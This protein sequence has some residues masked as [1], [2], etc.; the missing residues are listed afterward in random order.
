[1]DLT[2]A[3]FDVGVVVTDLERSLRFYEGALGLEVEREI[4][5]PHVGRMAMLRVGEGQLKLVERTSGVSESAIP[6]GV[7]AAVA[8][9][10]YCTFSVRDVAQVMERC[11]SAG[12]RVAMRT[13][14]MGPGV[15]VGAVEDPDGNWIEFLQHAS[16]PHTGPEREATA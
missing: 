9:F 5:V 14:T 3:A 8:G 4:E 15:Q 11:R 7:N 13:R 16:E 1:M 6:G 2:K 12:Y 10:R